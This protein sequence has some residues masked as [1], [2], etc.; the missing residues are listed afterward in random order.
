MKIEVY[1]T[2]LRD[3]SQGENVF[4]TLND[5]IKIAEKLDEFGIDFIEGGWPG[6]NPKDISFFKRIKNKKFKNSK[7][8]AFGST[9]RKNYP[10]EKDPFIKKLLESE[11]E[12]ITIFGKSWD[13]HVTDVLKISLDEN[14]KLIEETIK[15][16]RNHDRKVFFDA[17]HFFDGY[18]RNSEYALKTLIIAEDSGAERIVLCD[19]NGG[20]LPFEIEEIIKRVKERIK[21]PIGIHAHND[22]SLGVANTITAVKSGVGHIQGTINGLGERCGN[23]DLT[24][25][26]P[27]L[28]IKMGYKCIPENKIVYLTELSRFVYEI[29]NIIPP[30][31][32]PFVGISAFAHKG[33]IHVDAVSKNPLTYEH[34]DPKLVGNER[35]ILLSELSGK[36]TILQKFKN[37]KLEDKPELIKKL[38]DIVG[39]LE[40]EGY[41]FE[42]AEGSFEIIIRKAIGKYKKLFE[43]E[44]FRVI[45]EKKGKKVVS[46]AT[47]KIKVGNKIEHTASEGN[48]PVNALDN[49]LRKAIEKFYPEIKTMKLTDYKVRILKPEKA[50][51]A[52]T[53]VIIESKDEKDIWGTVGV[54]ENII[55]ASW[56]ALLDSFEY[57]ILK[58]RE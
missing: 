23:A 27:I 49:A 56:Q 50:T 16:L 26:I 24:A 21:T 19:T 34:I 55:E 20:S 53:R 15:F 58:S 28:Q 1:D 51:G 37:Y 6:S 35:R 3:G 46:E 25:I 52:I 54:S 45:V 42:A 43:V 8:V 29:A 38:V 39:Q 40:N 5:K 12:Y 2:T 9:R 44:G 13:L 17:E 31:N 32:Q 18:K 33:G 57:K 36:S 22:S 48:G 14:L 4:F 10:V 11:T 30:N 47:V 7:I 41:Q